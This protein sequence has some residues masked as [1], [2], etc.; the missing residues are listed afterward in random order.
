MLLPFLLNRLICWPGMCETR[1]RRSSAS[2]KSMSH[3]YL[4]Q[5]KLWQRKGSNKGHLERNLIQFKTFY[6]VKT[7]TLVMTY[8]LVR[9]IND[10]EGTEITFSWGS[11]WLSQYRIIGG[12]RQKPQ[13]GSVP[14]SSGTEKMPWRT[15]LTTTHPHLLC[16]RP[17]TYWKG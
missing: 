2:T 5:S 1:G 15:F 7:S 16:L 14:D 8:L 9:A 12:P 17:H 3:A 10:E 13:G 6:K 11:L 4:D